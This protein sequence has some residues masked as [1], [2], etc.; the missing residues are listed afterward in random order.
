ME[1]DSKKR[2]NALDED[3]IIKY[4]DREKTQKGG[5][6]VRK[7]DRKRKVTTP[8]PITWGKKTNFGTTWY[9]SLSGKSGGAFEGRKD[10][11]K[12]DYCRLQ[13]RSKP[14]EKRVLKYSTE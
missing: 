5:G 8:G 2:L 3:P 10:R 9:H 13:H 11:G 4:R 6:N 14:F 7:S 1:R 12:D